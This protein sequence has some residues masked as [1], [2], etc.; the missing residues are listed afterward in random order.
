[1]LSGTSAG[2]RAALC[3]GA[4]VLGQ[5]QTPRRRLLGI[6][7]LTLLV[8]AVPTVGGADPT[9]SVDALRLENAH[10]AAQSRAAVLALY[11]LDSRL[12]RARSHLAAVDA[13]A[14]RL[15]REQASL[16]QQL[17]IARAG[18]AVSQ[19][20]L[21]SRLRLLHEQRDVSAIEVVLGARTLDDALAGLDDLDRVTSMDEAVLAQVT[22]A[23][24]RLV[25]ATTAAADRARKFAS[26]RQ[27]AAA[28][29]AALEDAVTERRAFIASLA[30]QQRL[31]TAQI[32]RLEA[33]AEAARARAR[34][35][36]AQTPAPAEVPV[37]ATAPPVGTDA[38]ARSGLAD[39][40]VTVTATGYA[41]EGSTATGLPVGWGVAAVDPAVIPLGT[42]LT[43]PGYGEAVAADTGGAVAGA[44]IDLW[45]PSLA[46]ARAWGRR[47]VTVS[48]H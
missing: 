12:E 18:V 37:G 28:T 31:R 34:E 13:Q 21:S 2:R 24:R 6:A 20:R 7:V 16:G 1:V 4:E 5:A 26:A 14:Q 36:A 40:E 29:A 22:T 47:T 45:F 32:E 3:Y 48:L 25:A 35:L 27:D 11:G 19:A 39:R 46:Q 42:K 17:R 8:L 15:R 44:V 38:S 33:A 41:L 43:V 30:S 10:L 23:R 9:T